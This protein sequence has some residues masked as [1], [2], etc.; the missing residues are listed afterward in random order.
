MSFRSAQST[1]A[2][3]GFCQSTVVRTGDVLAR[4]GKMAELFDDFSPLQLQ[5]AGVY[6]GQKFTLLG[7]L[8]YKYGQGTWTEWYAVFDDPA[9]GVGYLSEDNGAFV[10]S[11]PISLARTV[12]DAAQFRVG[13]TT[14]IEGKTFSVASNEEVALLSAQGELPHLPELGRSFSMVELRSADG[15]VLSVDYGGVTTGGAPTVSRGTAVLLDDLQLTGL[16][17]ASGKEE[18]A[19]QFACPNC[20]ASVKVALASSKSITCPACNSLI[21][22]S[23]GTGA[24][25]KHA[26]QDEPVELL[27]QLGSTGL[28]QGAKWQVVG[29]QHRTGSE[30]GDDEVFGW[31]EYLLYNQKR[32]FIFLVDAE[33][34]WS[35][36]KPTTGAP[37]Y[38]PGASSASYLNTSYQLQ[39][40]YNAETNYVAGE[41]YWQVK[42]GEKTSNQD[43]S[44]GRSLLSREQSAHEVT[45]SSGNK[46]DGAVVAAAFKLD[47]SKMMFKR[48]DVMPLSAVSGMSFKT[49]VILVVV[50]VLLLTLISR[51][52]RC[53][54]KVENC[55]S[56]SSSR[57]SGGSFGGFS[58][59]G[60]HK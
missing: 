42:R 35:L 31:S 8:Q 53:D 28:L 29:F 7:R 37:S 2:V 50:G 10:F 22:L 47:G 59:G 9:Q 48:A 17:S 11:L 60:G 16:R 21:D 36:V 41:F 38:K 26:M 1:H 27:I 46:L 20:G 44:S 51:C 12:P 14:A 52:S 24:Q 19:Q 6:N 33:D 57:T 40:T 3:C 25:L 55:S 32:G 43:F 15:E 56:S 5:T 34:G 39:S 18:Q 4:V 30:P 49:I 54:P 13:A 58:G 45:W 23:Q